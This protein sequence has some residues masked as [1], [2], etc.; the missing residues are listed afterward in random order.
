LVEALAGRAPAA[1]AVVRLEAFALDVLP[2]RRDLAE[3]EQAL[4]T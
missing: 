2:S 1:D 4:V 3:V